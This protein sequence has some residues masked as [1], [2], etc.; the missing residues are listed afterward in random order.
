MER[1]DNVEAPTTEAKTGATLDA[2]IVEAKVVG[3]IMTKGDADILT[4]GSSPEWTLIEEEIEMA[5]TRGVTEMGDIPSTSVAKLEA[6]VPRRKS[7]ISKEEVHA[8]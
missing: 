6:P 7:K 3:S 1:I 8:S 2:A 5:E 4:I